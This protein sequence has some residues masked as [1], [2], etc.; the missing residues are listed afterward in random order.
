MT[1]E[2]HNKVILA[3]YLPPSA[4]NPVFDFLNTH[5]VHF[6]ITPQRSSKLGDYRW[7]QTRHTF[8]EISVNG[9]LSPHLFLLVLLHEMAHLLVFQQYGRTVQPHGH[10]WQ[11]QYAALLIQYANEGHFPPEARP[12][13][14]RYTHRIPL[15]RA[16]GKTLERFLQQYDR[17]QDAVDLL[18]RDLPIGSCF[19]LLNHPQQRFRSIEKRRTRYRCTDLS[20]GRDYLVSGDAPVQQCR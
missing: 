2:E 8:H 4:I 9:D 18:L 10:Q 17:P 7:P 12:L 11:Q 19:R 14:A 20:S 3:R 16:T 1:P 15:N 13:L 6:H 5:S